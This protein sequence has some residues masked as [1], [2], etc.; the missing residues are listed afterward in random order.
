MRID[1][2]NT[3]DMSLAATGI[4]NFT[5]AN[6]VRGSFSNPVSVRPV[7]TTET[8]ISQ[9]FFFLEDNAGMNGSV[10]RALKSSVPTPGIDQGSAQ[11]T[12]YLSPLTGTSDF[13]NYS[14]IS[15]DGLTLNG[16]NPEY[17]WMDINVGLN[18]TTGST[19]INYRFV[20]EFI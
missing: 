3:A 13:T 19:S 16:S 11:I 7:K 5:Y 15:G 6:T 12:G 17:I 20:Y 4:T 8:S 18:E 2:Y 9:L 14:I 10:F 1:R